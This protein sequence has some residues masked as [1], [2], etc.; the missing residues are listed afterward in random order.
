MKL[1]KTFVIF[2]DALMVWQ[3]ATALRMG[4]G[5]VCL[6]TPSSSNMRLDRAFM[7]PMSFAASSV[8]SS[9]EP[10]AR[11]SCRDSGIWLSV[12]VKTSTL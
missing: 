6:S 10:S 1:L 7:Q 2:F 12:T 9:F 5:S 4:A 11:A 3:N 8:F